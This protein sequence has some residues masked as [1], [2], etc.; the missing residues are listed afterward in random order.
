MDTL[1][2]VLQGIRESEFLVV[3]VRWVVNTLES[4]PSLGVSTA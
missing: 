2:Q 4:E 3:T 1:S